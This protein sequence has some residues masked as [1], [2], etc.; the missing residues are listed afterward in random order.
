[1][2]FTKRQ[3]RQ[4]IKEGINQ[5]INLSESGEAGSQAGSIDKSAPGD[6]QRQARTIDALDGV[7]EF[8]QAAAMFIEYLLEYREEKANIGHL[9]KVAL[10]KFEDLGIDNPGLANLFV[11]IIQK[12]GREAEQSR[13]GGG[14]AEEISLDIE[15]K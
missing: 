9:R 13:D 6:V 8:I 11:T 5:G 12:A 14:D 15:E 3:L 1:M 2:K 7:P 10:K 4:I